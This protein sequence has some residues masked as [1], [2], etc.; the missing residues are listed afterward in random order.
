MFNSE[1]QISDRRNN[2]NHNNIKIKTKTWKKW[3]RKKVLVR[4]NARFIH[5]GRW[6]DETICVRNF[7]FQK[8][9]GTEFIYLYAIYF[10]ARAQN[11]FSNFFCFALILCCFLCI[12]KFLAGVTEIISKLWNRLFS[13]QFVCLFFA[14]SVYTLYSYSIS[15]REKKMDF[16]LW[17]NHF[18]HHASGFRCRFLRLVAFRFVDEKIYVN[19]IKSAHILH[20]WWY[21]IVIFSRFLM[22]F[23]FFGVF[24]P[25]CPPHVFKMH[26]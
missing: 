23:F 19:F 13:I 18:N 21:D 17:F 2:H 11:I 5:N 8:W 3:T 10:V 14:L 26:V 6:W 7:S 9:S 15:L 12:S 1:Q 4:F 24:I 16:F 25:F 20:A 22:I